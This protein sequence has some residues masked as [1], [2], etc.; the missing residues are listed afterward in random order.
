MVPDGPDSTKGG[1]ADT[2]WDELDAAVVRCVAERGI[3]G[4]ADIAARLG[5]S[6]RAVTSLVALL[7]QE[8]RL[9]IGSV[10]APPTPPAATAPADEGRRPWETR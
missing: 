5:L 10:V 7:V 3:A 1:S 4:P 9:R 2:W 8:G 6:E